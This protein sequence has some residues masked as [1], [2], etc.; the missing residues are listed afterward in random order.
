MGDN[1]TEKSTSIGVLVK[2]LTAVGTVVAT[3]ASV[4]GL[5]ITLDSRI[6][7]SSNKVK[8]E[9]VAEIQTAVEL[10]TKEIY[11]SDYRVVESVRDIVNMRIRIRKLEIQKMQEAGTPVPERYLMELEA[12]EDMLQEI[13][14][15]W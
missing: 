5:W 15:K 13:D 8:D 1:T 6:E 2:N 3:L 4:I 11:S 14:R 9:V 12:F 10:I 7:E